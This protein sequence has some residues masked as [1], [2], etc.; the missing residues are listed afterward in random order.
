MECRTATGGRV[1]WGVV[2][3]AIVLV[4]TFVTGCGGP[5]A[6]ELA[7]RENAAFWR[8]LALFVGVVALVI[9]IVIGV[10]AARRGDAVDQAASHERGAD[11]QARR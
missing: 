10:S 8:G 7:A 5:S 11:D 2:V 3:L 6:E 9:G 1:K 4:L